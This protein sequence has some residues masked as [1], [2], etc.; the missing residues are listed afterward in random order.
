MARKTPTP[1]GA[2]ARAM[3]LTPLAALQDHPHNPKAHALDTLGDSVGRFGY[4]EPI[5]VDERT[6]YT[7]SG[8]GRTAA[9]RAAEERGDAAPE[10]VEVDEDGVWL[11]PVV[12]GWAS[13][14][15]AEARAALIALN[16]TGELGG[17]NEAGLLD[18]LDDLANLDDGLVG[19]GYDTA[20]LD[21]LTARLQEIEAPAAPGPAD[22]G[23]RETPSL[24]DYRERY[25][26]QGRRL[27]VLDYDAEE[28]PDVT[29]RLRALREDTATESNADAIAAMLARDYPDIHGTRADA[30]AEPGDALDAD[31]ADPAATL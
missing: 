25:E 26:E 11:V 18:L 30:E 19:I 16:R 5:V 8:H 21:D 9:L 22:T 6:G 15:D 2:P 10:G 28:Y 31:Y 4:V 3:R 29:A 20:D 12:T 1:T 23:T 27:I 14:N 17:W 13:K 24:N 7:I